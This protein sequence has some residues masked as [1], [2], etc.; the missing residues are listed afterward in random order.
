MSNDWY[1]K[2]WHVLIWQKKWQDLASIWQDMA[3]T[4]QVFG[5]IWQY[6]ACIWHACFQLLKA[7]FNYYELTLK[8]AIT[9]LASSC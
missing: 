8:L 7:K 3:S 5:K 6:L 9:N 4:W 1:F 2:I